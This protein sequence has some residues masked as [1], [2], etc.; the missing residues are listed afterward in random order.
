MKNETVSNESDSHEE[1]DESSLLHDE[2]SRH[3]SSIDNEDKSRQCRMVLLK[4]VNVIFPL[5]VI[6][7]AAASTAYVYVSVKR[8]KLAPKVYDENDI[9]ITHSTESEDLRPQNT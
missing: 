7:A 3:N 2:E 9:F 4:I 1:D 5:D 8:R 6:L